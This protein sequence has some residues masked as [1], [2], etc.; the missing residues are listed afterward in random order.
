[1]IS[2]D[3]LLVLGPSSTS[4]RRVGLAELRRVDALRD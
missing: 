4:K 2:D 1:M 3:L